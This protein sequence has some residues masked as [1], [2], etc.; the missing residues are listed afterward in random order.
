MKKII[1]L[2]ILCCLVG[3]TYAQSYSIKWNELSPKQGSLIYFLPNEVNDFYALRWV[4]GSVLG[5][6]QVS[7][8]E[9]LKSVKK[10][11]IKLVAEKSM[12]NFEGARVIDN[13]FIVF[14][15]DKSEGQNHFYMQKY[16]EELKPLDEPNKLASY[17]LANGGKKGWFDI[18]QS[19]NKDFFAVI[20]EIPGRSQDRDIYGFKVFDKALNLVNEGEYP[21]PFKANLSVIHEHHISNHGDYFLAL[22]E[23]KERD[24][25]TILRKEL[26]F[27]ALH[28]YQINNDGLQDFTIDVSGRRVEA[29]AISSDDNNIFTITGIY[30]DVDEG[31]VKGVFFQRLDMKS[32]EKIDDGFEEFGK[33]FITQG[34]SNRD[35]KRAERR[36]ERGKGEP[37]LYHYNLKEI[38]ILE[39]GSIVGTMEQYYMQVRSTY[40]ARSGQSSNTYFYYYNDIIAYKINPE[41]EF[42][43]VKKIMKNQVSTNDNGPF[44]S[45]ECFVDGGKVSFIF[46][47]NVRNYDLNGEYIEVDNVYSATYSKRNNV[48]ALASIDLENG[49][50]DRR[51]F[52]DRNEIDAIAVPKLFNVNYSTGQML[53]YS[54][55]GRKERIGVLELKK[56]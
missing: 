6:Y 22:T 2:G 7:K 13:Q 40:D 19:S 21:L 8:H 49:N 56:P 3:T 5:N 18:K 4:G 15:S 38:T 48:V 32:G 37:Q 46:N 51:T 16:D 28:I 14:L 36:E 45:Y 55:W 54:V 50:I 43:W 47:D 12:A 17:S 20:W 39:D 10:G 35:L 25:T 24:Q 26:D 29:M 23:Y 33:E 53:L 42:D 11:R 30:G 34:W 41:G 27:K 31:G 9:D 1:T 44:S 52:F